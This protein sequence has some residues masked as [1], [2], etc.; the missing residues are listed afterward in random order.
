MSY[1]YIHNNEALEAFTK[2]S[3]EAGSRAD[4]VQGGGGNTSVKLK[5]GLMAIKAS[6]YRLSDI[7]PD[8][9]YAVLGYEPLREFYYANEPERFDDVEKAGAEKAKSATQAVEGLAPLRPSVEAGFHSI[10]DTFVLHSHSVY[11]NLAACAVECEAIAAEALAGAPYSWGV[12][13]YENPGARLTFAVRDELRRVEAASGLRPC[14][15]FMQN[16]GLIVHHD[17][18]ESALSIHK[19]VNDRVAAVFG[20]R[21]DAFPAARLAEIGDSIYHSNTPFLLEQLKSGAYSE[22]FL[23][24]EP[25]YPDQLVFLNGTFSFGAKP[26]E[27]RCAWDAES[28]VLSYNM[29][30]QTAQVVEETLLAVTFIV[31]TLK[32]ANRTLSVMGEAARSFIANWESEQ[33]RKS[34]AGKK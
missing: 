15:L 18:M 22:E 7:R 33:Y 8:A 23:L 6:G 12:V 13:P 5:D 25:L 30:R 9:A 31:S 17:D 16:H 4:Y 2:M 34:L 19:E 26:G 1:F 28:G 3:R 10:L 32:R 20:M 11:A 29:E 14:V 21:G 24:R 27:N